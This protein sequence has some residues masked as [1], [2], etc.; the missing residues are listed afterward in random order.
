MALDGKSSHE[1]AQAAPSSSTNSTDA[2][3]QEESPP[4]R[5]KRRRW[6]DAT[7]STAAAPAAASIASATTTTTTS[8]A[9]LTDPKAKLKAMQES[10]KARLEAAKA[11]ATASAAPTKLSKPATV[12][13]P[14]AADRVASLQQSIQDRLQAAKAKQHQQLNVADQNFQRPEKRAKNYELDLSVTGPTFAKTKYNGDGAAAAASATSSAEDDKALQKSKN[15]Y[16]AYSEEQAVDSND[17]ILDDRLANRQQRSRK[18]RELKFVE[19][20]KWQEIAQRRREKAQKIQ[21]AGFFSGRKTAHSIQANT[22]G[23]DNSSSTTNIYGPA[24]TETEGGKPQ[25]QAEETVPPRWDA[26]PDT[27]MPMFLEWWDVELLPSRLRKQVARAETA[28]LNQQSK[29]ALV[30]N[31]TKQSPPSTTK[32][33]QDMEIEEN[34]SK[35]LAATESKAEANPEADEQA[36]LRT[37]C[38]EQA[39]LFHCKTADLVQHIVPIPCP[40]QTAA[41]Q[42]ILHLTRKEL[43]RQRKLRRQEKQRELQDLQAAGLIPAPEPRLTLQNFI[44]VLGDQ[45]FLDPSKYEQKVVAQIQARQAAHEQRNQE[46]KLTKEQRSAKTN[47]K[48]QSKV[49][50]A[51]QSGQIHVA[52]FYVKNMSH[53]YH[54]T[55]VDLNAQQLLITGGVLECPAAACVIVEGSP[56]AIQ[57]FIRLMTVRMNWTSG[58]DVAEPSSPDVNRSNDGGNNAEKDTVVHEFDAT[59]RC[60]MVWQGM[61]VK[62]LFSH[63][64][65]QSTETP[66]QCRKILRQKGLSHYWDQVMEVATQGPNKSLALKLAPTTTETDN[67]AT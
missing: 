15:P 16:L 19:P 63:F 64:S 42:P 2:Q 44:R 8:M 41:P 66:D 6:G 40:N 24:A 58:P 20:G 12:V 56:Q 3:Q 18:H 43:K 27:N 53:P 48:L 65:F 21:E 37:S 26:H 32:G 45:A 47:A 13:P 17:D 59:N 1:L 54:R 38:W 5:R 30:Q 31:L 35:T 33:D 62:R 9:N 14:A 49:E 57:K 46:R 25:Q 7:P 67:E 4:P 28:S 52:L 11:A 29:A 51:A 10:I 60:E 22:I 23:V 36:L 39:A 55:K 50:K 61:V 34:D